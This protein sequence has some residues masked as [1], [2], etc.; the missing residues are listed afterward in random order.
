MDKIE[1]ALYKKMVS[2][3]DAYWAWS[4]IDKL[5]G[6]ILYS[7]KHFVTDIRNLKMRTKKGVVTKLTADVEC[8]FPDIEGENTKQAEMSYT[9]SWK[10]RKFQTH[11]SLK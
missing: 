5:R 1:G 11:L 7:N 10:T 4:V 3:V 8:C 9:F 6:K 2:K